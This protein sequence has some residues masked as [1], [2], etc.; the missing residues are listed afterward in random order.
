MNTLAY[1]Q[2]FGLFSLVLAYA[3]IF[4][5]ILRPGSKA[6]YDKQSA[7]PLKKEMNDGGD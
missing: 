3:F 4:I 6:Y 5:W 2:L 1:L 7:I